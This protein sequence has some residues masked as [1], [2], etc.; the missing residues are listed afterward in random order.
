MNDEHKAAG[1]EVLF[2]AANSGRGFISFYDAVFGREEITKRYLIKGGPG[3]GKSTLMRRIAAEAEGKGLGVEYYRCS[4]DPDS[5]DA[6]IIGTNVAIIDATAPHSLDAALPGAR[7][8]IVDLGIFWDSDGLAERR[9][10]IEEL[11]RNK[12][13]CYRGAYRLLSAAMSVD[14]RNREIIFPYLRAEK[15]R[16]AARRV[17]NRIP[18]G[19]GYEL[20]VGLCDSIGMK[21]RV[22][23]DSFEKNAQKLYLV[24]DMYG[25]GSEFLSMM[26]EEAVRKGN[27]I[28]VSYSPLDTSRINALFFE[29]SGIAFVIDRGIRDGIRIGIRRFIDTSSGGLGSEEGKR[30][31]REYRFNTKLLQG[32][33]RSATD[34][35]FEAGEYH[36]RLED[37]YKAYMNFDEL[38]DFSKVFARR[39]ISLASN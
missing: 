17:A 34:R 12:S 3:T 28:R 1:G 16:K 37:I 7:D 31:K 5:L 32:L 27:K 18:D 33:I 35:L 29:E 19:E 36:F 10:E 20:L 23:I 14:I 38:E 8:D 24:E 13:N 39:V 6:V 2:A 9:R 30:A 26:A 25:L 22:Y 15:M 11:I 21:G 4:S